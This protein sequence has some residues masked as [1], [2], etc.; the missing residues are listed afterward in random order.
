MIR[1]FL[2]AVIAV[3]LQMTPAL[4]GEMK[5]E[6]MAHAGDLTVTGAVARATIGAA[7]NSAIYMT[8]TTTGAAD[9][10]IAAAS[11]AAAA[12]ELHETTMSDGVM[13]MGRVD[14]IAVSPGTETVLAPGGL[15]IMLIGLAEPLKEGGMVPLTLTFE[16]AGPV[17]MMVPIGAP[18]AKPGGGHG[19]GGHG[20]HGT[21][22]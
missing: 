12:V 16:V 9:R 10:L 1:N 3:T 11:P 19:H 14:G 5:H 20:S 7:P 21:T 17:E 2:A 8:I 15:H 22:N 6:G 13:Q 18:G 4:A